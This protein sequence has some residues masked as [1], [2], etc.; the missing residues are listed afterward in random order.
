MPDLAV[1]IQATGVVVAPGS[2][3]TFIVEVRNLGSVVERYRCEIVGMDP[4]WVTVTPAS[5]ELFPP[6]DESRARP[7]APPSVGRFTVTLHPPRNPAAT[8]G[9][10]PIGAKVTGEHDPTGRLV[11]ETTVAILP[12]G[13]LEAT[14]HP[15]IASGRRGADATAQITNQGNRPESVALAGTDPAGK[16]GFAFQPPDAT[17]S[18]GESLGARVHL[19]AGG[20]KLVG[21]TGTRPFRID[22]RAGSIDTEPRALNGSLEHRPLIPS[23]LPVALAA[24]AALVLGGLAVFAMLQSKS[25][26]LVD[27]SAS[28][29]PSVV[30]SVTAPPSPSP[31]PSP[32]DSPSPSP[33]ASPSPS[34]SPSPSLDPNTCISGYVW[35]EAYVG[36]VVCVTPDQRAVVAADN[37]AAASRVDPGG[38]YGPNTCI[39]GYVWRVARPEDLVCVTPDERTQVATDNDAAASRRVGP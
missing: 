6:H 10:W 9:P 14:L 34:P 20:L 26:S 38:A 39:T 30:A 19:S 31:S 32:T 35:R 36:D 23:G 1:S 27:V 2:S 17:I 29:S 12:F 5:L 24:I 16:I 33:S 15:S 4:S 28:A 25:A 37:A 8:A 7:D 13:A 21:S 22:I 18:P 3:A 11:E